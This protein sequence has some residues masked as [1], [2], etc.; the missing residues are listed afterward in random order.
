M[1]RRPTPSLPWNRSDV[2]RAEYDKHLVN[3]IQSTQ[4]ELVLLLGWMHILSPQCID[5][6]PEMINI[7]PA[8]L[9]LDSEADRV[10]FSD[11]TVTPAYRGARAVR[12]ALRDGAHWVGATAHRVTNDTDRGE[13]LQRR[14]LRVENGEAEAEVMDRLHP[15]E[16]RVLTGAIMRWVYER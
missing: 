3:Q 12:D 2:A 13:V 14:P 10:G 11:G 9:P 1:A 8:F 4:P 16:H 7:H 15:L 6:L 5:V